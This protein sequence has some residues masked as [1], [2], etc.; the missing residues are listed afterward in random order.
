MKNKSTA[1]TT[2]NTRQTKSRGSKLNM[3][4][5][6]KRITRPIRDTQ[7]DPTS[8][9]DRHRLRYLRSSNFKK[10][11]KAEINR[12][13]LVGGQEVGGRVGQG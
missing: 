11:K 7:Q 5:L 6:S 10:N 13:A 9:Q 2:N 8:L 3:W 4:P 1:K 12:D